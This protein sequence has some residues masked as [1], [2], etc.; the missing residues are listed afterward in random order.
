MG[1]S[2][3]REEPGRY[4]VGGAMRQGGVAADMAAGVVAGAIAVWA[5]DR[6]DWFAYSREGAATRRRTE[7]VRPGG[8]DPAHVIAT[9]AERVLGVHPSPAAHH[10]IGQAIHYGIGIAPAALY[11]VLRRRH[12]DVTAGH[13][14]LF[15]LVVMLLEDETL[16]PLAGLAAGPTAYPWQD[17]ARSLVAHL[18]H[19][20]VTEAALRA[21]QGPPG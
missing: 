4:V 14:A 2:A 7:A 1:A 8:E 6:V 10:A 15:G 20:M 5:L 12:P 18:V 17:H 9:R 16:N 3:V 13:G 21:L 11:A 19:G